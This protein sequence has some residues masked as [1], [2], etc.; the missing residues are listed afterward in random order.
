VGGLAGFVIANTTSLISGS[1]AGGEVG[2]TAAIDGLVG[3]LAEGNG[4]ITES[5]WNMDKSGQVNAIGNNSNSDIVNSIYGFTNE[6][7]NDTEYIQVV[8]NNTLDA[9]LAQRAEDARLA[10]EESDRLAEEYRLADET[11]GLK[12]IGLL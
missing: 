5:Y 11:V 1:W 3:Q 6:Q 2:G 10:K 7:F 9:L 12:K 4:P 8:R